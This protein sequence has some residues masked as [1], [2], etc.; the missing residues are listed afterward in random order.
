MDASCN[1]W[2]AIS[3]RNPSIHQVALN[4]LLGDSN[5]CLATGSISEELQYVTQ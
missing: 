4:S 3:P 5:L 1:P 2:T